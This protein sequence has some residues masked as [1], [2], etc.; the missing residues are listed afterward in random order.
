[1]TL[2]HDKSRSYRIKPNTKVDLNSID[3]KETSALGDAD[4]CT[5]GVVEE[6]G[7]TDQMVNITRRREGT[8]TF[9]P[10]SLEYGESGRQM[11]D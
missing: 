1:M 2:E 11:A 7:C 4:A 8:G 3:P 6:S 10:V 5:Q 9:Q